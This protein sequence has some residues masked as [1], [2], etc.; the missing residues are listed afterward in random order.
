LHRFEQLLA[1]TDQTEH[2][3]ATAKLREAVA[4]LRRP[5]LADLRY[6]SFA[7]PAIQRLAEPRLVAIEMRMD[8]D[9]ALGRHKA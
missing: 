8:A 2:A 5:P 1:E 3:L 6:E 9:L 7:Q 4:L